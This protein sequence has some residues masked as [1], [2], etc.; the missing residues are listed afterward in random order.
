[1]TSPYLVDMVAGGHDADL[2]EQARRSRLAALATCC[3]PGTWARALRRVARAAARVH[4]AP[5]G[6]TDRTPVCCESA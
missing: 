4:A 1:M 3:R 6:E 2:R 5:R